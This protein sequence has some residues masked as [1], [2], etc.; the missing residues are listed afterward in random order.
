[1]SQKINIV[2]PLA[3]TNPLF[4]KSEFPFSKSLI[5][6]DGKPMIQLSIENL[7]TI[8]KEIHFIFLVNSDDCK[9]Y[10]L[11]NVLDLLTENKPTI[12]KIDHLTKGAACTALL[13]ID[14]IDNNIPLIISN[15][16]QVIKENINNILSYFE[17]Y[18]TGVICT[19]SV[20]PRWSYIRNEGDLVVETA[21]K[22]PISKNAI[23]GFFYFKEGSFFVK[24]A[25]RMIKKD[26][27]YNGNYYIASS[28]NELIL[29]NKKIGY[30]NI[31][32]EEYECFYS[33]EKIKE[34]N[35]RKNNTS[36]L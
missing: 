15:G 33:P 12:I 18:E 17:T 29:D 32:N 7:Q 36:R 28:I 5:E 14:E 21:E 2:I 1:M 9:S 22:R 13:A 6:I 19:N 24:S 30:Y 8:Q 4:P 31:P 16:D 27:N 3:G 23:A 11:D 20:H 34:Y 35:N 10:Y 25:M 26:A